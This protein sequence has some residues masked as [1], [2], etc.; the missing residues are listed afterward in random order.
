MQTLGRDELSIHI[1]ASPETV[2]AIVSDVAKTPEYSPEV[3]ACTWL[4]GA[5]GPAVGARFKA[6]NKVGKFSWHNKPIVT[7]AEPAR[8]FAFA[9]T[10]PLCG[11]LVWRYRFE[12]DGEGTRVTESYE[13]ARPIT[14]LGWLV[15][16]D[17][18]RSQTMH[19]G[20]ELSLQRLKA[21]AEGAIAERPATE[22]MAVE[23][24]GA[25]KGSP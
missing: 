6:R 1:N 8:E 3:V 9:R 10:E 5:K 25:E 24:A 7:A 23:P 14:R 19:K 22:G 4:K 20:I 13:V 16:G 12:P 15:I 11:T 21:V 18:N 17:R 2:Y